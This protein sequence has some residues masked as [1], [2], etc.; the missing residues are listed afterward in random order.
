MEKKKLVL[1][2]D[3][4][5]NVHLGKDVFLAPYYMGK[6]LNCEVS[7]VYLKCE[8]SLPASWRGVSLIPIGGYKWRWVNVLMYYLYLIK[9]AR[10]ID[11]MM[12]FHLKRHTHLL[13]ILYKWLNFKGKTYV[14][15]DIDPW[16]IPADFKMGIIGKTLISAFNR[17]LDVISCESQLS[18]QRMSM[19]SSP[20][21]NYGKKLKIMANGFDEEDF[22]TMNIRVKPYSEKENI[23]L[24]VGRLGTYQKNTEMFL[25]AIEKIDLKDWKVYLVGSLEKGF[26]EV[27]NLYM[28]KHP[29]WSD[30]VL[31]TG[32]VTNR[33]ELYELFNKSK[34]FVLPSR[35][36]S[37]G[38]VYTEAQRFN[39]YIISTPVGA[40]YDII[41]NGKYGE[42]VEIEDVAGMAKAIENVVT[43]QTNVS[44][45]ETFNA[46]KLAWM[47]CVKDVVKALEE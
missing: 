46:K 37:Y 19:S 26:E 10:G 6:Q 31:W 16:D 44:V 38:I 47:E 7:I 18:Y 8:E 42:I 1:F 32:M 22:L 21:Y 34:V 45:F 30:K 29:E 39:N 4:L 41:D 25:G 3:N 12:R 24:T 23:M 20:F 2:Y 11:Y 17:S 5:R 28:K 33:K 14:K 15:S 27:K 35:F 13:V 9:N 40:V 36:E 43:G